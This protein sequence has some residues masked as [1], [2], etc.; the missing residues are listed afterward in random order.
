KA[1]D[2]KKLDT[3]RLNESY[4][5]IIAVKKESLTQPDPL[6]MSEV[7]KL[8]GHPDHL[9]LSKAIVEGEVPEDLVGT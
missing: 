7:S 9:R 6:P 2:E 4:E 8:V 5:K 3:A 1:L